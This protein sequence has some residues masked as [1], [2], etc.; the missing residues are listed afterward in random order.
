MTAELGQQA[1]PLA[2][3]VHIQVVQLADDDGGRRATADPQ[4]ITRWVDFAN[5]VYAPV[6]LRLEFDP[7]RDWAT[8]NNTAANSM[9]VDPRPPHVSGRLGSGIAAWYPGKLVVFIRY[10]SGTSPTHHCFAYW[11]DDFVAMGS[12]FRNQLDCAFSHELGHYL[13]L[14]HPENKGFDTVE[15]AEKHFIQTGR[16]PSVY[17]GDGLSDTPPCP[18]IRTLRHQ[19]TVTS[20]E[21][22]GVRF[23]L[24]RRNIM[25]DYLEADSL[26]PQQIAIARWFVEYRVKNNMRFPV[27]TDAGSPIQAETLRTL[28]TQDCRVTR[29]KI[30]ASDYDARYWSNDSWLAFRF[31]EKGSARLALPVA[32]S[33]LYR[34]DFY[35]ARAVSFGKVQLSL[36]GKPLGEPIDFYAPRTIP[37][38]RMSLDTMRLTAGDHVL[39]VEVVG[40]NAASTAY[41]FALDCIEL[42]RS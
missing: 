39:Q 22:D 9:N 32:E 15:E 13:G 5:K 1:N 42:V 18:D 36:D 16:K 3:T 24:P 38:G 34:L 14:L 29:D 8:L 11:K 4:A 10:G 20:I 7:R 37:S 41:S 25:S 12:T 21:L 40:R 6:G 27:N 33:G 23:E 31:R 17:E 2:H 35:G 26:T 30:P 28:A 19:T